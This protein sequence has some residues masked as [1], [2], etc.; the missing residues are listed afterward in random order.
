VSIGDRV[1]RI[2]QAQGLSM[3]NLAKK[4]GV[5]PSLISQIERGQ[6][7]PSFSTLK[8]LGSALNEDPSTLID[9]R[10]PVEWMLVK[11]DA[12]RSVFTGQ[13]GVE[14]EL[15]AFPGPRDKQMNAYL[16]R[17]QP[18]SV[19]STDIIYAGDDNCQDDFLFVISGKVGI[20]TDKRSYTIEHDEACY[21][22]YESV[23]SLSAKGQTE[24]Q[25]LW[26][27]CRAM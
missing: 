6:V 26:C 13:E 25:V 12:R 20:T 2:R 15:F 14:L 4:V 8:G 10:L 11:K 7:S 3:R 24:T 1:R 17:L 21:L 22:T 23:Q 9:D 18:G 19:F 16:V 5:S 27:S